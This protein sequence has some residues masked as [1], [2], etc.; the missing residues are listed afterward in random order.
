[1]KRLSDY[2]G[3][4]AIL[5]WGDLLDLFTDMLANKEVAD[6]FRQRKPALL[7]AKLILKECPK[8]ASEIL[9]RIDN[10]PLNGVNILTRLVGVISEMV[11]DPE[12]QAFFGLS[13]EAKKEE[14]HT[15]SATEITEEEEKS[16]TS[17]DM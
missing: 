10:T 4:E 13:A 9:L 15:G 7:T 1:M 11:Q 14:T 17:S 16:D 3:E 2:E 12:L 5:L 8:Q 6:S